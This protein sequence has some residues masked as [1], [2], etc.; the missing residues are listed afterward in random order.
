MEA[1]RVMDEQ[2]IATVEVRAEAMAAY[3]ARIQSKMPG[4]V[5]MSGC[6]SWYLDAEGRNTTM[7]PDFTFRFRYRTRRFDTLAYELRH[8]ADRPAPA[9]ALA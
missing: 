9:P 7:W 3:N 6:A 8:S 2:G 1:V 4:T 5:W